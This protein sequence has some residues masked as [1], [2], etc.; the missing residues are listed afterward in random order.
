MSV[1]AY[2]EGMELAESYVC[3]YHIYVLK[4][5]ENNEVFYVGKTVKDLKIRLSGHMGDLGSESAKGQYLKKLFEKGAKPIIEDVETIYGTCYIDKAKALEREIFW[6]K[7]YLSN[8]SPLTN[9]SGTSESSSHAEYQAYLKDVKAKEAKW[10]YYYCGKTTYGVK[11]FDEER[12]NEDGFSLGINFSDMT[13]ES[14]QSEEK[15]FVDSIT[16]ENPFDD[17]NPDYIRG[18]LEEI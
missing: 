14:T 3:T 17:E 1:L 2:R 9:I 16:Y 6:I 12:I 4:N 8:G 15:P 7:Y 18:S 5:P 13:P 10:Y 11:V